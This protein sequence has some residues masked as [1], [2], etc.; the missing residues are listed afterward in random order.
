M[1][2]QTKNKKKRK[3]TLSVVGLLLIVVL[4]GANIYMWK[5]NQA[6]EAQIASLQSALT[7]VQ[8]QVVQ[9][10]QTPVDLE[11]QLAQVK[12]KL[13]AAQTGFPGTLNRNEVL[14]YMLNLAADSGV[15][16]LPLTSEGWAEIDLG[17]RYRVLSIT[18]NA[19]GT[20]ANVKNYITS[21]QAG[22]YPTLA[23]SD[24]QVG[25]VDFSS[26][27]FPRDEMQVNA[28]IRILIYTFTPEEV[29]G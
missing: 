26:P 11:T 17:Q 19:E 14:G 24:C 8:H 13:A 12:E 3:L 16:I 22:R 20:L 23:I 1:T 6:R 5:T 27:G 2:E 18:A 10:T 29:S 7:Q 9:V 4:A 28:A 15:E 25:R 21:L